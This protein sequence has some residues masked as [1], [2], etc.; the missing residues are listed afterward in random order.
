MKRKKDNVIKKITKFKGATSYNMIKPIETPEEWNKMSQEMT[1]DYLKDEKN[2]REIQ[3]EIEDDYYKLIKKI[4]AIFE[5][6]F[7][8]M[9]PEFEAGCVQC[10]ANLIYNKF[11]QDLYDTFVK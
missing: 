2:R 5:K 7:G 10:K 9:C 3:I 11:K 8:K 1:E 4:D 6:E